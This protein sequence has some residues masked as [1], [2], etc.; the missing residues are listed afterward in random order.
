M[1]NVGN[2]RDFIAQA[3]RFAPQRT[4]ADF[5]PTLR[6]EWSQMMAQVKRVKS[7]LPARKIDT[8]ANYRSQ[9]SSP[10]SELIIR[11]L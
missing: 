11:W 4:V 6:Q 5:V 3:R 9:S 8:I 2:V 1:G 10:F 7:P